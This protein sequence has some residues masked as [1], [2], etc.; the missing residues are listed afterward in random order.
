VK[1]KPSLAVVSPFLDKSHGTER[2]V[3]EWISQLAGEFEIHVYSQRVEDVDLSQVTW[4]R[5]PKLPGPHLFNFLWWFAANYLWRRWDRQFRG[6]RYDLVFT[7]GANCFDADAISVHIVFGEFLRQVRR[8]LEFHRNSLW[9]WPR[10]LHRRLY[11]RLV[12]WL[13]RV[14]YANPNTTLI[15]TA[16]KT[17]ADLERFYGRRERCV[18]LYTGLDHTIY[19][20]A[21]RK[22]LRESA[23]KQLG[24]LEDRFALLLVG[25]DWHKKGIRALFDA[26][27]CLQDLPVDLLVVG[28]DD[29]TPF[30]AMVRER[31]LGPRVHFYP[32]RKDIEFYYAAT[33]LYTGPS[34]EDTFALPPAEAMACGLPVIVTR[35]MG[36][37]EIITHG[38]D[39]LILEDARDVA[40][41]AA[42]I[43]RLYEDREFRERLGQKAAE[44]ARQY[45]W[46]RN[47]RELEAIFGDVLRRKA[48][49]A[50]QTAAQEP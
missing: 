11:Y 31:G 18:V 44:T 46:E 48:R 28:G 1:R 45:T 13:E 5:I 24:L 19:H 9:F 30:R 10:L 15:L 8:E 4:H 43:R 12:I 37:S 40:G 29:P 49:G 41:L 6:L 39:G 16:K 3:V 38:E 22:E 20:T 27:A 14:A 17:A 7:P 2:I 34:L 25:N 26:L 47:G 33:D 35:E 36:V 21:R 32:I 42:M 50:D 23:R